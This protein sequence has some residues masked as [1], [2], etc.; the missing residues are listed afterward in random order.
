M[1]ILNLIFQWLFW[2][3][4][5]FSGIRLILKK[6]STKIDFSKSNEP[7][8]SFFLWVIGIYV[9]FFGIASQ[10]YE[11]RVD[12]IEN[13]ANSIINQPE[14]KNALERIPRVQQMTCPYKPEI[15]SPISIFKSFLYTDSYKEIVELLR[16][17]VEDRKFHLESINLSG[18]N[19][20][21]SNLK[22]SN[23]NKSILKKSILHSSVFDKGSLENVSFEQV[24]ADNASFVECKLSNSIFINSNIQN[25]IFNGATIINGNYSHSY[26]ASVQFKNC[27]LDNT[28][29][30]NAVLNDCIFDGASLRNVDFTNSSMKDSSLQ[31]CNLINANFDG[32]D[33]D[34]VNFNNATISD[35]ALLKYNFNNA[36]INRL[37]VLVQY[38]HIERLKQKYTN[39]T[40]LFATD[41]ESYPSANLSGLFLS[42]KNF[43]AHKLMNVDFSNSDLTSASIQGSW[44]DNANFTNATLINTNFT[45]SNMVGVKMYEANISGAI[46][47]NA[48]LKNAKGLKIEQICSANSLKNTVFDDELKKIIQKNC[49]NLLK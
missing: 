1:K 38:Q 6:I 7:P 18:I 44:L 25:S 28:I 39:T 12:K 19:L 30:N 26:A 14:S 2:L 4:Y 41:K 35:A 11:Y 34:G 42:K 20:A 3:V 32:V 27:T 31:Y 9:G 21:E 45:S 8:V 17:I 48:D 24:L 16:E 43:D 10:R 29:F 49:P 36:I 13:R 47:N 37:I 5:D 15:T 22:H 23:M 46:F 33:L 40:M